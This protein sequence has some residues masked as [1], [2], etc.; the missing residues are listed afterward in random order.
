MPKRMVFELDLPDEV[1]DA[2]HDTD[3]SMKAKE[4][5]VMELLREHRI[6]QGKAAELLHIT[7]MDLFPLMTKYRIP[8]LDLSKEEMQN[9]LDHRFPT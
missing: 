9:E 7:R 6:S 4:A 5:L 2:L 1:A 8:V 3:V